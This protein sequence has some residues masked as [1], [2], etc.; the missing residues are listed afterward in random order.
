MIT[1]TAVYDQAYSQGPAN[2]NQTGGLSPYGVMGLGGNVYEWEETSDD[3]DNN[4]GS[5][6]RGVRGGAWFD[7]FSSSLSSST[8]IS[9]Y[10]DNDCQCYGFRVVNLISSPPAAV[11]EPS[12]MVIGTLF[13]LGGLLA[14]RQTRK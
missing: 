1:G 6:Q 5:S 2:V 7:G 13:G 12:M 3:L 11:P 8:R 14:K 10:P 9:E 4:S